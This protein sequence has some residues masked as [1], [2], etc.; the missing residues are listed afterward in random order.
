MQAAFIHWLSSPKG[1]QGEVPEWSGIQGKIR[2]ERSWNET[3]WELKRSVPN[4]GGADHVPH[5]CFNVLIKGYRIPYYPYNV[6][7]RIPVLRTP[8]RKYR[9]QGGCEKLFC[10]PCIPYLEG[11]VFFVHKSKSTLLILTCQ[12]NSWGLVLKDLTGAGGDISPI[13][14]T[15]RES[16]LFA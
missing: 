10:C 9:F 16:V 5:I 8:I 6:S 2:E 13:G 1:V 7:R 14:Q 3:I 12:T 11:L 4:S 15:C